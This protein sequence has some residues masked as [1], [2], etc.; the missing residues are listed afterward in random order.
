MPHAGC[1]TWNLSASSYCVMGSSAGA[2]PTATAPSG[3]EPTMLLATTE[4]AE[5]GTPLLDAAS[6]TTAAGAISCTHKHSRCSAMGGSAAGVS[7]IPM[8][9]RQYA[10]E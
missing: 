4:G 1:S 6:P 5:A 3:A 10:V 7:I 8:L 2:A 9:R